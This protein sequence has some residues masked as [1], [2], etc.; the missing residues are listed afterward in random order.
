MDTFSHRRKCLYL[1]QEQLIL[2]GRN[3]YVIGLDLGLIADH[4]GLTVLDTSTNTYVYEKKYPLHKKH[5]EI[6]P[7]IA[8][9]SRDFNNA[10]VVYDSTG[11][12]GAASGKKKDPYIKAY[13]GIIDNMMAVH[14]NYETKQTL[15]NDFMLA[16]EQ[17]DVF[18]PAELTELHKEMSIYEFEYLK[19]GKYNY[20]APRG[21]HDDV[22]DSAMMAWHGRKKGRVTTLSGVGGIL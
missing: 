13:R 7:E 3:G 15:V 12:G 5:S 8:R 14:W 9:I 19:G 21:Q 2:C 17:G 18:I 22:L 1:Y 6:A 4:T 20:S 16:L 10:L 11:A